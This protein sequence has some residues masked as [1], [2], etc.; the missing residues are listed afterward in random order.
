MAYTLANPTAAG[1]VP[2]PYGWPGVIT[3]RLNERRRIEMPNVFFNPNGDLPSSLIFE[4]TRPPI[5][6]HLGLTELAD[7]LHEAVQRLVRNAREALAKV[8][9]RFVGAREVL[10]ESFQDR[11]ATDEL[12]RS[13]IPRI[14]A[15]HTPQRI[16]AI[17]KLKLF[18]RD[19][20]IAWRAW[21]GGQRN[22]V[23]PAGTY[24]LRVQAG[25][26]CRPP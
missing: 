15:K 21:R 26:T 7:R 3:T 6:Q 4:T 12:R 20:R 16:D 8:G 11:P 17:K 14:A 25:V 24:A 19:Y 5:Y 10:Q 22:Q 13:C 23:F 18:L 9:R 1:L 2:S